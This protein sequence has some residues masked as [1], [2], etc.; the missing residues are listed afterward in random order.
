MK[1]L[2]SKFTMSTKIL[3]KFFSSFDGLTIF[4]K[5]ISNINILLFF[6]FFQWFQALIDNISQLGGSTYTHLAIEKA[7]NIFSNLE[8]DLNNDRNVFVFTNGGGSVCL[9]INKIINL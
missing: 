9:L 2:N 6:I 4:K 8:Y 7:R 5:T 3:F 1:N